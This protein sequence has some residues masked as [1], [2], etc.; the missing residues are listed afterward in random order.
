VFECK[1]RRRREIK[2]L[3]FDVQWKCKLIIKI[4]KETPFNEWNEEFFIGEH[5]NWEINKAKNW[6]QNFQKFLMKGKWQWNFMKIN[7]FK[8]FQKNREFN[9]SPTNCISFF[10]ECIHFF[11]HEIICNQIFISSLKELNY[12]SKM[13]LTFK[14]LSHSHKIYHN[15]M[16]VI[17][18]LSDWIICLNFMCA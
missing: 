18:I 13:F 15:L 4:T 9:S 1:W 5:F 12:Q 16:F 10:L 2:W 11:F 7:N 17:W 3:Q 14:R 8:G 6:N